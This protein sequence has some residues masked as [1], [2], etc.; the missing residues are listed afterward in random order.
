MDF[1]FRVNNKLLKDIKTP[2][3]L[4]GQTRIDDTPIHRAI[5]EALV[6]CLVNTDFFIPR[7]TVIKK[8]S[9]TI[10]MENPGSIRVG[11]EQMLKGGISEPRNK[12]LLKMFNMIGYGERAGSGV[13]DILAVWDKQGWEMPDI[14][15]EYGPDRTI[16]TLRLKKQAKKTSEENKRR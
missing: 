1:F 10:I 4:D 15:E 3:A 14:Q 11:R 6:N 13:P 16:L 8:E 5:R 7:G 2:F 9:D 12:T